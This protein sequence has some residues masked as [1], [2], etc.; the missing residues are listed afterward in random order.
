MYVSIFQIIHL[1]AR[2]EIDKNTS[3]YTYIYILLANG[4][5]CECAR[6]I[7]RGVYGRLRKAAGVAV[8]LLHEPDE[9]PKKYGTKQRKHL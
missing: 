1:A 5:A 2:R 7:D 9:L 6:G 8:T 3:I 4:P